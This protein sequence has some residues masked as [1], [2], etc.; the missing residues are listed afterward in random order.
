ML[1]L[2]I[3]GLI[4]VHL[5]FAPYTKV[6]ESFNIQAAHDILVYGTPT[7]DVN[8]RLSTSY[9]HFTFPGAVP[10]TFI[11]AVLLAGLSQPYIALAGFHHGQLIVRAV[12][13]LFNAASI[14]F[15][16]S[17]IRR[18]YG[19]ATARW[20]LLLQA[21]QFHIIFY[22][23]RTLPNMFAFGLTT[24][25][26]G[27]L[28]PS[29]HPK[30]VSRRN[31]L[32]ITLFVFAAAVF[33]SEV[34]ILLGT[35][36]L[37]QLLIPTTSLGLVIPPFIVSFLVALAISIP[38]DSYFWQ[39]PLWPEL[40]G[41]YF[42]A[43]Q[44]SSSE[45]G[46]SPWYYYFVSALPR[47]LLN[48]LCYVLLLPLSLYHPAT[49]PAA[50]RLVIPSLLFVAIY[51]LQPHKEARFIF[52]V[53]PPLT[54]AC[55]L[56]ANLIFNR[57]FS[58]KKGLKASNGLGSYIL[59]M[60]LIVSILA[61]FVVSTGM[62]LISSLNYPGGEALTFLR[63]TVLQSEGISSIASQQSTSSA[64]VIPAH[65]DVL[66]CMTGVTLFGTAT[67]STIPNH[68]GSTTRSGSVVRSDIR[69][70]NDNGAAISS[71]DAVVTLSLDKT[72]DE[73][74]LSQPDFWTRFDYAL[75]EDP[76][77]VR[78]GGESEWE[79][80]GVVKGFGGV[81]VITDGRQQEEERDT[82]GTGAV[83]PV[84]GNGLAVERLKG[85]VMELTKGRWIGPRMVPKVYIMKRIKEGRRD[86]ERGSAEA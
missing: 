2:L 16:A 59:A 65:A 24:F 77:K 13:G 74:T 5:I 85:L 47:L 54:A 73:L 30:Q 45:W 46:V 71:T 11:G 31:R 43:I 9:D 12:L 4:L 63:D 27:F 56:S 82:N 52:Y 60:A 38:V 40:W 68:R 86:R 28:V 80:I 66:S 62:L 20:Y 61:S 14:L 51:S 29:P 53:V 48:P 35:T 72:E 41:F 15:F 19:T 23:S 58:P 37:Y 34:A 64:V 26:F 21:S 55:A 8:Y 39:K 32:A 67:G 36:I 1:S 18:A 76:S 49:R 79:I 75:A 50:S 17:N 70:S 83:I 42:N 3:P 81:E 25:A 78:K 33:R 7:S 10:R 44:G 22:A 6:E 84:V 57:I 69:N